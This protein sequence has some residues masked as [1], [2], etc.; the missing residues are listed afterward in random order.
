[1]KKIILIRHAKVLI[2]KEQKLYASQMNEWVQEYNT[3]SI[4]ITLPSKKTIEYIKDADIVYASN[5]PRTTDSLKI[6]GIIPDEKNSL[7]DELSLPKTDGNFLKLKPNS[8]LILLRVMM[9]LYIGRNNDIFLKDKRR[10]VQ[11]TRY[12]IDA[13]K[14]HDSVVLMGH[15]GINFLIGK[16]L[17]KEGWEIIERYKGNSNWGYRVYE[18]LK[19]NILTSNL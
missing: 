5:L 6:V 7:F 9:L 17:K 19:L 16:L 4:D 1:M 18:Q 15:G 14:K 2:N 11:A 3:S 13:T 10:S 8:W 12:L